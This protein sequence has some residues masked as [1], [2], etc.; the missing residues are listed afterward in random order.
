MSTDPLTSLP[1]SGR[2]GEWLRHQRAIKGL[3][4]NALAREAGISAANV[5]KLEHG[6]NPTLDTFEKLCA[7]LAIAPITYWTGTPDP[8]LDVRGAAAERRLLRTVAKAAYRVAIGSTARSARDQRKSD[9]QVALLS[10]AAFDS[11]QRGAA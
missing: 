3:S 7:A 5:S 10:L 2:F 8:V 9:L 11:D 1:A 4:L 6:G